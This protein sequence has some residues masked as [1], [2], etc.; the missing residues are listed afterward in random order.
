MRSPITLLIV[1]T[2]IHLKYAQ[3]PD[4]VS[5]KFDLSPDLPFESLSANEDQNPI[6]ME[7]NSELKQITV[8]KSPSSTLPQ[9][10]SSPTPFPTFSLPAPLLP[11]TAGGQ[12]AIGAVIP[13]PA[14]ITVR[15]NLGHLPSQMGTS[16]TGPQLPFPHLAIPQ[17][18]QL[19]QQAA[20][21]APGSAIPSAPSVIPAVAQPLP[22]TSDWGK[23]ISQ[24]QP[25]QQFQLQPQ[26]QLQHPPQ[27]QVQPQPQFHSQS[28]SPSLVDAQSQPHSQSKV[29]NVAVTKS[30]PPA[31][32]PLHRSALSGSAVPAR[33][34]MSPAA[35]WFDESFDTLSKISLP[36]FI[37]HKV[38]QLRLRSEGEGDG[39]GGRGRKEGEQEETGR[40]KAIGRKRRDECESV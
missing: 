22:S 16:L 18:N 14:P 38:N 23:Q 2:L 25:Q 29:Q 20:A 21:F 35:L 39:E 1:F 7:V 12:L 32:P 30:P 6:H 34:R 24:L 10:S 17:P 5:T 19:I 13:S 9:Q 11:S 31:H 37:P 36:S 8:S 15:P 3:H 33:L 26:P 28:Q 40:G 27:L 4:F